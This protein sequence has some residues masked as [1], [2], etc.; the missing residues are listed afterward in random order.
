MFCHNEET[1]GSMP[2]EHVAQFVHSATQSDV[3]AVDAAPRAVNTALVVAA[4]DGALDRLAPR[5]TSQILRGI[6]VD[7]PGV[8]TFSVER[9]LASIGTDRFEASLMM[10]SIPAIVSIPASRGMTTLPTG[11]IAYQLAAGEKQIKLPRFVLRKSV[12]RR[13]LAVAIHA[14]LPV[15]EAAEKVV[16]PRWSWVSH[17]SAR[18]AIGAFILMLAIAIAYPL[19]GFSALH[20]TSIFVMALGMAEQDGL[21]VLI[22]MAVGVLSLAVLAASGMSARALRAKAVGWLRKMGRKLGLQLFARFLRRHGYVRLARLVSLEW[23]KLVLLWDAEKSATA[24]SAR[25]ARADA[26]SHAL[27]R[28]SE[29]QPLVTP[30]AA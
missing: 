29:F 18:R 11:G 26:T 14:A 3:I 30:Q 23:S 8:K 13:A 6:L 17:S 20:A 15:L 5:R 24:R 12:S 21:A 7:N 4:P 27:R 1:A 19:F 25:R 22:G 2:R 9:I 10:F 16:R 28:G